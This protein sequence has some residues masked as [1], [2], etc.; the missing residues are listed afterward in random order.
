MLALLRVFP[1]SIIA[2]MLCCDLQLDSTLVKTSGRSL[3]TSKQSSSFSASFGGGGGIG[4]EGTCTLFGT[5]SERMWCA[6]VWQDIGPRS[7][8]R[9]E[10]ICDEFTVLLP[11][12]YD[13]QYVLYDDV[14]SVINKVTEHVLR[15]CQEMCIR[16]AGSKTV[17]IREG[18]RPSISTILAPIRKCQ[19]MYSS[20]VCKLLLHPTLSKFLN[21]EPLAVKTT[22]LSFQI[23]HFTLISSHCLQPSMK[24]M[25]SLS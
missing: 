23:K 11:C 19:R 3:G 6:S 2:P 7:G 20:Q 15:K 16:T 25:P 4:Q 18:L 1:V 10:Q 12:H 24:R 5:N 9:L 17:C 8:A 13:Q 14:V 22:T 21:I